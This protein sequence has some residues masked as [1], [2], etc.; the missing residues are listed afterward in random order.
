[1]TH[2]RTKFLQYVFRN[3]VGNSVVLYQE[4]TDKYYNSTSFAMNLIVCKQDMILTG[5]GN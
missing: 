1:M 5:T 4:A 2:L 3:A